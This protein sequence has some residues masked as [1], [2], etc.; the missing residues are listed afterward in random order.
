M[1]EDLLQQGESKV[2]FIRHKLRLIYHGKPFC[3]FCGKGFSEK[4]IVKRL[5]EQFPDGYEKVRDLLYK[6]YIKFSCEGEPVMNK[7]VYKKKQKIKRETATR[8][9][10]EFL[11]RVEWVNQDTYFMYQVD[12]VW[13]YG[14]Y[15]TKPDSKHVGDLDIDIRLT[16]KDIYDNMASDELWDENYKR[17]KQAKPNTYGTFT[18]ILDFS[19]W[20]TFRFL[21][22][23]SKTLSLQ[24][25]LAKKFPHVI[26]HKVIYER[27][28]NEST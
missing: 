8:V 3:S 19:Y 6:V 10:E 15:L 18:D 14:S 28:D 24:G 20:E 13:L 26:S 23:K 2:K 21:K 9:L 16:Q 12:K 22:N 7:N 11:K 25:S 4:E 5:G 1:Q 27:V 17:F